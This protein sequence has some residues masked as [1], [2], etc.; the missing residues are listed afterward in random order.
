MTE[1]N[2]RVLAGRW[3]NL[4]GLAADRN[5]VIHSLHSGNAASG[6]FSGI[7]LLVGGYSAF[8]EGRA[9]D[10]RDINAGDGTIFNRFVNF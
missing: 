3:R 7:L 8:K 10:D 6:S 5:L 4:L 1:V 9:T 2:L